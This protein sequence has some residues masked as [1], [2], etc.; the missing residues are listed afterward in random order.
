MHNQCQCFKK[1]DEF[2]GL[3]ENNFSLGVGAF[4]ARRDVSNETRWYRIRSAEVTYR[5]FTPEGGIVHSLVNRSG[6]RITYLYLKW[7]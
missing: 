3:I 1:W 2:Y 6:K 7:I 5:T 4:E